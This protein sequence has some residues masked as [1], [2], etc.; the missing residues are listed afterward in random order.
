ML[1]TQTCNLPDEQKLLVHSDF[2]ADEQAYLR[3]RDSLI[4]PS[5]G[6][7]VAIHDGKLIAAGANLMDV[8]DQASACGGHPYIA[9]VGAEDAVVFRARRAVFP[10]D[11]AYQPFPLPHGADS[12]TT[13]FQT[14]K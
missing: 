6:Q 8:I 5:G 2:M 4:G 11:Q 10:C 7:W 1:P 9:L 13:S 3:M 12:I 14:Q